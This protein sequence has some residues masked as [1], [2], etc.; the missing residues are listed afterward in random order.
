MPHRVGFLLY[1]CSVKL[2][3]QMN[4]NMR[5]N[6]IYHQITSIHYCPVKVDKEFFETIEN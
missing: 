5:K 6:N 4:N 1:F 2:M 3:K